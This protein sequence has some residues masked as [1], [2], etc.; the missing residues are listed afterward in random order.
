MTLAGISEIGTRTE[1]Q[2][3]M[4]FSGMQEQ[5]AELVTGVL[6]AG[7]CTGGESA[8]A[9]IAD[10]MGG[11]SGGAKISGLIT[12]GMRDAYLAGDRIGEPVPFLQQTL[13]RVNEAVN[14]YL[15][16][17]EPGGSTVIAAYIEDKKLY[18][19]SV[20]DSRIYLWHKR[21]LC[22]LNVEHTY[23]HD[24]DELAKRGVITEGEAKADVRRAALTSY[25]G[26]GI[27]DQVDGN[28]IPILLEKG[29]VILLLTD[30]AYRTVSDE[31]LAR[32]AARESAEQITQAV[33]RAV[34]WEQKQRQDNYTIVA[35]RIEE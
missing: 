20:G 34:V 31:E 30:G 7:E 10:G 3:A 23:G 28:E 27:L 22:S 2:D 1:Q 21:R 14:Q 29:D 35:I 15:A 12:E 8:F 32:C 25:I 33:A 18:Y 16:G 17:K 13:W 5:Q 9:V 6:A 4:W 26:K 11:L 19:C 24:L